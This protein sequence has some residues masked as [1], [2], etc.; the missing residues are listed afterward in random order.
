MPLTES[1]ELRAR[2]NRAAAG[3]VVYHHAGAAVSPLVVRD[4]LQYLIGFTRCLLRGWRGEVLTGSGAFLPISSRI[5]LFHAADRAAGVIDYPGDFFLT[6][7]IPHPSLTDIEEISWANTFGS[8][9]FSFSNSER[10]VALV[11]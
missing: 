7:A 1:S 10:P 8:L 11:T 3:V 2:D 5:L 4:L 9:R 6:E